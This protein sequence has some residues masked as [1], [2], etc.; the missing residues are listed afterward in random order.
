[1]SDDDVS[2]TVRVATCIYCAEIYEGPIRVSLLKDH[3]I[4]C[5]KHPM[6]AVEAERD[7]SRAYA[8]NILDAAQGVLDFAGQPLERDREAYEAHAAALRAALANHQPKEKS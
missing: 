8:E 5:P 6:R 3:I 1:M 2:A 4:A 7:E